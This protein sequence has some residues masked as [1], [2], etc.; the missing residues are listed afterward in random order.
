MVRSPRALRRLLWAPNELGLARAVVSGDVELEGD[1]RR[2]LRV[3][4]DAAGVS[5]YGPR[6]RPKPKAL[7]QGVVAAARTGALGPPPRPPAEEAR[8]GGWRH[9]K[10]RD[11]AAVRHHYEVGN[12]FYQLVLGPAMTY[13][14]ARFE[15]PGMAL[16]EAQR[17]KHDLICRKLGLPERPG[18]R[19]LD[20]GCGWGSLALHAARHYGAQ[21]VGITLSPSQLEWANERAEQ[22]GLAGK[23]EFRLQDYRDLTG[24]RFD[25]I[26]SVGMFEHVGSEHMGL[27]FGTLFALLGPGGRLLNHAI[28]KPGSSKM[29]GA[30]FIARYIFPDGEL[31]DVGDVVKGME[32]AGFEVRD[33]ESLREHY[34]DTLQAWVANLEAAW[35][36][37]VALVGEAR[38]RA[39]RLY[40]SASAN[41]FE[42]HKIS[43]H[44]VLG[45]RTGPG[46][47]SGMPRTRRKW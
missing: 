13:S 42:E 38:A 27:Y 22:E 16:E 5:S 47:E 18:L 23:V 21:A 45:V 20:V 40:M 29:K 19:L 4:R 9:S 46:G 12:D 1:L 8:V 32:R 14:C 31:V 28:S 44:Q 17:R 24:E 41:A 34:V 39:W 35:Q 10:R 25:V 15:A 33:V 26:S 37:A 3:L 2:L 36:R 11:S 7:L 30:R 43:V 6:S